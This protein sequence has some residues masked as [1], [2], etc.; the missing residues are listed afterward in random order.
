MKTCNYNFEFGDSVS[1]SKFMIINNINTMN[2]LEVNGDRFACS[3]DGAV[4]ILMATTVEGLSG[5]NINVVEVTNKNFRR[6][7][8]K[9][10]LVVLA[11]RARSPKAQSYTLS[12]VERGLQDLADR[13]EASSEAR[14]H[15]LEYLS[16][17]M[18]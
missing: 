12:N 1:F 11:P 6:Y 15:S 10:M 5:R 4:S 2:V 17:L 3:P 8:E 14:E 16:Y 9:F 7:P 13:M 18:S